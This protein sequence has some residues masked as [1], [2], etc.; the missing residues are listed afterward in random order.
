MDHKERSYEEE[1][2]RETKCTAHFIFQLC[3]CG[4]PNFAFFSTFCVSVLRFPGCV[5]CLFDDQCRK[6]SE[7]NQKECA[8]A[9]LPSPQRSTKRQ[10]TEEL[11]RKGRSLSLIAR[12]H[13]QRCQCISLAGELFFSAFLL[14]CHH[15][16][17]KERE[18]MHRK[19]NQPKNKKNFD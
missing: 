12:T 16:I 6:Y 9:Q 2:A 4:F 8:G 15:C 14:F 1:E 13:L 7:S 10:R 5:P 11:T 17:S 19:R 3:W 18:E